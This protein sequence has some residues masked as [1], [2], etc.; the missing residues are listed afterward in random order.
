MKHRRMPPP[1][2]NAQARASDN[3]VGAAGAGAERKTERASVT[4]GVGEMGA[5]DRSGAFGA[6]SAGM[7]LSQAR[8][9]LGEAWSRQGEQVSSVCMC[10]CACIPYVCVRVCV[11]ACV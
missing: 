4:F 3:E 8:P 1:L 11:Y 6:A 9:H 5:Q 7:S 10:P 2:K